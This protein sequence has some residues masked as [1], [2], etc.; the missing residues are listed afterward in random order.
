MD[1]W[2]QSPPGVSTGFCAPLRGGVLGGHSSP[3]LLRLL[4]AQQFVQRNAKGLSEPKDRFAAPE[5]T[6]PFPV[7]ERCLRHASPSREFLLRQPPLVTQ[8]MQ[9]RP[10][11][12]PTSCSF[13]GSVRG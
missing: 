7:C 13:S 6:C 5:E 9:P 2:L 4:G 10:V 12:I 11:R 1:G 3:Q 8:V